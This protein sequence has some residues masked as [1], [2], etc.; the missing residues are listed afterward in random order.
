MIPCSRNARIVLPAYGRTDKVKL[1]LVGQSLDLSQRLHSL[2]AVLVRCINEEAPAAQQDLD[3]ASSTSIHRVRHLETLLVGDSSKEL[4][5][6]MA[7]YREGSMARSLY[8]GMCWPYTQAISKG[9]EGNV[10]EDSKTQ[11][12]PGA[13]P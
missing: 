9:Q 8:I 7:I 10:C 11:G 12:A 4:T 5:L 6:A 1:I 2:W 13:Q 3:S